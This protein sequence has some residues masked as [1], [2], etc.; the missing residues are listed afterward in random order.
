MIV[1]TI[2]LLVLV[3]FVVIGWAWQMA[4]IAE[5]RRAVLREIERDL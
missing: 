1:G 4:S 2:V 3:I 5:R